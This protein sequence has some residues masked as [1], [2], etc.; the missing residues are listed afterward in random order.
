MFVNEDKELDIGDL[1]HIAGEYGKNG[2]GR[3]FIL[4]LVEGIN[5]D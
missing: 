2:G 3:L 1:V 4:A 5:D